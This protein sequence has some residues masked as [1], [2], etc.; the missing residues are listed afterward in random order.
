MTNTNI[1]ASLNKVTPDT[2]PRRAD[3][4]DN[5]ACRTEDPDLFFP[6]GES[7]PALVQAEEAKA[8]CNNICPVRE[9]CL[10]WAMNSGQQAGVWGGTTERERE[11]LRRQ[12]ARAAGGSTP[13]VPMASFASFADAYAASTKT[14]GDHLVWTGGNEVKVDGTRRSPNQVAWRAT[15]GTPVGQVLTDCDHEGCVQHLT[16]QTIRDERAAHRP[17]RAMEP[18]PCGTPRGYRAHRAHG[19]TACPECKAANAK[20]DWRLRHTG[21]SKQPAA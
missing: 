17:R 10:D 14:D 9:Q 7:G 6:N 2:L 13:R 5:A 3:W 15:R 8:V 21:T 4:R 20:A 11:N 1:F 12:R 19:E 16:D 18:A